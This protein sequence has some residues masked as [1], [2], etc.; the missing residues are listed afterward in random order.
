MINIG[1]IVFELKLIKLPEFDTIFQKFSKS[2]L[3]L[4]YL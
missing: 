2:S 3:N 1:Q 4:I